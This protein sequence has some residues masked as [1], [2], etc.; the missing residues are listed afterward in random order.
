M[1]LTRSPAT[2]YKSSE[3]VGES[4]PQYV[5]AGTNPDANRGRIIVSQRQRGPG[6]YR[7]VAAGVLAMAGLLAGAGG[8]LA[9]GYPD[10]GEDHRFA[11]A[12]AGL[13]QRAIVGGFA[14]GTFGPDR[15]VNRGQFAKI[16]VGVVGAHTASADYPTRGHRPTFGDVTPAT[17]TLFDHI[18]EAAWQGIV[19]GYPDGNFGPGAPLT[20]AQLCLMVVRAGGDALAPATGA[21]PFAD[22]GGLTQE[23]RD[24][25]AVAY[26]NGIVQGKTPTAFDPFGGATRGHAAQM[27][28]RL[29]QKL[30]VD[31]P[32]VPEPQAKVDHSGLIQTYEGPQT[33]EGCHP[34]TMD[35]VAFSLHFTMD[36]EEVPGFQGMAGRY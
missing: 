1:P 18:E 24:A 29:V 4:R 26:A 2:S 16:M 19:R 9:A 35:E 15:P 25:I 30:A 31:K 20:R 22:L 6:R 8:A 13:S 14:D 3:W 5:K 10:V 21:A 12:I 23:A 11:E 7:L 33:C 27:S 32:S 17:S 36:E 28:W 34:G